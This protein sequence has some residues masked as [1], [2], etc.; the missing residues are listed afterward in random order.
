MKLLLKR[1]IGISITSFVLVLVFFF[2]PITPYFKILKTQAVSPACEVPSL[3]TL[4]KVP[5][6]DSAAT[7]TC[8]KESLWDVAIKAFLKGI[9]S[10]LIN[11]MTNWVNSGFNG[12][13]VFV[14]DLKVYLEDVKNFAATE[15]L[16]SLVDSDICTFFDDFSL[17]FQTRPGRVDEY[18]NQAR[19]TLDDLGVDMNRFFNS[20]E[21]GGW[22]SYEQSLYGSNN[23]FSLYI[24]TSNAMQDV[25]EEAATQENQRLGWASGFL[26]FKDSSG[27]TTTPGKMVESRL[28]TAI[29]TDLRQFELADE[30]DELFSALVNQ[31]V[32][33][34]FAQLR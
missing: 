4:L 15:F 18:K 3:S 29:G 25:I 10:S 13:P 24:D 17:V 14:Q 33:S 22:Y 23:P 2:A 28:S 27:K 9:L 16:S 20:F 31:L 32:S 19:C 7:A 34:A 21:E 6:T 11:S 12:S 8:D 26:S 5:V 30:F 1:N